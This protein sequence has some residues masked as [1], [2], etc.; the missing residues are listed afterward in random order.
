M[1]LQTP[2]S[3]RSGL[4]RPSFGNST[5]SPSLR[6]ST[7]NGVRKTSLQPLP[8]QK[9]TTPVKMDAGEL[10]VGDVVN[11]PGEMYGVVKFIGAVR[12]KN[13]Q[14]VGV[15]LDREFAARGKNDGDVD[16]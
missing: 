5:T 14:F 8:G 3:G 4:Q 10:D 9:S 11:V 16:G 6:V 12:G 1:A 13:G 2:H 15:E 7:M